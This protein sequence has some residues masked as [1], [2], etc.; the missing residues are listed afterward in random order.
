MDNFLHNLGQRKF[1]SYIVK[2]L[3]GQAREREKAGCL[4]I[5]AVW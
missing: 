2:K 4:L 5:M 3:R 1:Y